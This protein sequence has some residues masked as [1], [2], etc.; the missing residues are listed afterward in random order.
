MHSISTLRHSS[1]GRARAIAC[2]IVLGGVA[3]TPTAFAAEPA[4]QVAQAGALSAPDRSLMNLAAGAGL[5]EVEVSKLAASKAVSAD[6]KDYALMLAKHHGE[7]NE[8]LR[9]LAARK[10]VPLV[11][12]IPAD[13]KARIEA[14]QGPA[15]VT[16]FSDLYEQKG[17]LL[18]ADLVVVCTA[19]VNYRDDKLGFVANDLVPIDDAERTLT[20]AVHV[21]VHPPRQQIETLDKL[22]L[23]MGS[24]PGPCDVYLHCGLADEGEVVIHAPNACRVSPTRQLHHAVE[25]L[26]GQDTVFFSAGMRLPSHQAARVYQQPRWKQRAEN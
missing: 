8:T 22:A 13:K 2:A 25:E 11:A 12:E 23:I 19:R 3:S 26:M 7:S 16:V 24:V 10:S 6:V 17:A 18:V 20:K 1:R 5:Y 15:E 14:L 9:R 21:R 4:V